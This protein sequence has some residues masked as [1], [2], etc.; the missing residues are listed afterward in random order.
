MTQQGNVLSTSA[1]NLPE[2][3]ARLDNDRDF[4]REL[5]GI[6][7]AEFPGV[8]RSLRD[9]IVS[10]KA[11]DTAIQA[12]TL[13]GMLANVSFTQAAACAAR[14]ERMAQQNLTEG[15]QEEAAK[16]EQCASLAL[17]ELQGFCA[18]TQP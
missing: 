2:L 17:T 11:K 15:L 12:H 13:K 6:F 4:I 16:L 9:A 3:F 10:G 18:E 1:V 14:L 5:L 8:L 7:R